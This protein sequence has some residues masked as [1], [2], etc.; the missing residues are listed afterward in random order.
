[1]SSLKT[2]RPWRYRALIGTGGIGTGV[3]FAL[4]GNHTLGREESRAGRFLDRRDYCKLHIVAHHVQTLLGPPFA[5]FPVGA[6]GDDEAGRRL[7]TEMEA[8]GLDLRHVRTL[9]GA[10]TLYSFCFVY[11]DGSGGNLTVEDSASGRLT[12][13][14]VSEAAPEFAAHADEGI[15]LAVPEVPL[16]ARDALLQLASRHRFF[17]VAAFTTAEIAEARA[18]GMLG[19]ADLIALNRDEASRL[20]EKAADSDARRLAEAAVAAMGRLQPAAWVSVTAS[21]QGSWLWDG[22]AL[23]HQPAWPVEVASTAGAGDAHLAGMIAGLAARLT[24]AESHQL[25]ALVAA[26]SVTSPHT[27]H[28]SVSRETLGDLAQRRPDDLLPGVRAVLRP[29]GEG[30][31]CA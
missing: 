21:R 15:A 14:E 5:T 30:P 16:D 18:R 12:P 20:A 19:R 25:G 13:A 29:G 1:M 31:P 22:H 6:V 7:R 24:P 26:L 28:P 3:F 9:S 10:P 4:T 17:R 27:I 23:H 11:P 8:A 2:D